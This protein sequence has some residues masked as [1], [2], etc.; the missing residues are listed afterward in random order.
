MMYVNPTN[1]CD[2]PVYV[3]YYWDSM[4]RLIFDMASQ[5]VWC[6][7]AG[8]GFNKN[9]YRVWA[10]TKEKKKALQAMHEAN[11]PK[12]MF[13][14]ATKMSLKIM[15]PQAAVTVVTWK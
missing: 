12:I 15:V 11:D 8:W 1:Y 9:L 3:F 6:F 13:Y 4:Y 14:K 2:A 5:I 7:Y 10:R